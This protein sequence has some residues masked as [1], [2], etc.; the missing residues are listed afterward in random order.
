MRPRKVKG[1]TLLR[2]VR[3]CWGTGE[4]EKD[5]PRFAMPDIPLLLDTVSSPMVTSIHMELM[6]ANKNGVRRL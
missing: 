1:G 6:T 4:E 2:R 5:F 3:T